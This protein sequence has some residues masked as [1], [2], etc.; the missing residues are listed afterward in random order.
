MIQTVLRHVC[1]WN[2]NEMNFSG[3]LT[4][5]SVVSSLSEVNRCGCGFAEARGQHWGLPQLLSISVFETGSG[6]ELGAVDSARVAS[7][8]AP[9]TLLHLPPSCRESWYEW[10][11]LAFFWF[12][13]TPELV[14]VWQDFVAPVPGVFIFLKG[15]GAEGYLDMAHW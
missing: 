2:T 10:P 7:Q 12:C 14:V 5:W 1:S 11:R 9:E 3:I 4:P 6:I 8:Q 13:W 15:L